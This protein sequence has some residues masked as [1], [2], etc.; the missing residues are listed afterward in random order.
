[1][2]A[3]P[4]PSYRARYGRHVTLL[5]PIFRLPCRRSNRLGAS[6]QPSVTSTSGSS[7]SLAE[8]QRPEDQ[9]SSGRS[10]IVSCD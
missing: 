9:V 3:F 7:P 10:A 8:T 1:M 2:D 6:F 5:L 4:V